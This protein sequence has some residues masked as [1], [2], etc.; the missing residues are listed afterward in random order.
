MFVFPISYNLS[1]NLWGINGT[2]YFCCV[3]PQQTKSIKKT[4]IEKQV[5]AFCKTQT[6][7]D[8]I[9]PNEDNNPL[10][11]QFVKFTLSEASEL[12]QEVL[13]PRE[14]RVAQP[15]LNV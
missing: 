14:R 6:G 11:V 12:E 4:N 13:E 10:T 3:I 7:L 1:K 5:G 8:Q 2:N 9:Q 15:V